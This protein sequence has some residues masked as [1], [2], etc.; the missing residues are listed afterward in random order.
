MW[1][2]IHL[3]HSYMPRGCMHLLPSLPDLSF[4]VKTDWIYCLLQVSSMTLSRLDACMWE[5][6]ESAGSL[7]QRLTDELAMLPPPV[8]AN[9]VSLLPCSHQLNCVPKQGCGALVYNHAETVSCICSH[10]SIVSW[11]SMISVLHA[12]CSWGQ[13]WCVISGGQGSSG[14]DVCNLAAADGP[15]FLCGRHHMEGKCF[16]LMLLHLSVKLC[17]SCQ[18]SCQKA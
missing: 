5:N 3:M 15:A 16:C 7:Q 18:C 4:C 8:L 9:M 13:Q 6:P 2:E 12:L 14:F 1:L 11:P 10:L 17:Q